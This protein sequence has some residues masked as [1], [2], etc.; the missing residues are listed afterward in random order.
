MLS[1]GLQRFRPGGPYRPLHIALLGPP[2][3]ESSLPSDL[4]ILEDE[5]RLL[6]SQVLDL[7]SAMDVADH[8]G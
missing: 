3:V 2:F 7:L 4:P 1:M 5:M 6:E 8:E